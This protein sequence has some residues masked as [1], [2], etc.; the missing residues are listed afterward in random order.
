MA[1][2]EKTSEL[3]AVNELL[4]GIGQQPVNSLTTE[5]NADVIRALALLR[6]TSLEVQCRGLT[7]NTV[8]EVAITRDASDEFVFADEVVAVDIDHRRYPQYDVELRGAKLYDKTNETFTFTTDFSYASK[9]TLLDWTDL[10]Q[11]VRYYIMV[12]AARKF[13]DRTEGSVEGHQFSREDEAE[14]ARDMKKYQL[15]QQDRNFIRKMH[16]HNSGMRRGL[17]A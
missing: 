3:N 7:C 17:Y 4:D 9:T 10:P 8:T 12:R 5:A 11:S 2:P 6:R 15:R 14:A 13:M 16:L 1:A